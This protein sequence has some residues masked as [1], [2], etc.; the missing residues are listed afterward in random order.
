MLCVAGGVGWM[1]TWVGGW[2]GEGRDGPVAG[3]G[4]ED[5]H[6]VLGAL[7]LESLEAG[8]G[9]LEGVR[10]LQFG[11]GEAEEGE[12]AVAAADAVG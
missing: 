12:G 1:S 7:G 6:G 10:L 4:D 9:L 3:R 11:G 5:G 2:V 8:H